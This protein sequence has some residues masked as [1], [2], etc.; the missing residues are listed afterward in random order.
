M[1]HINNIAALATSTTWN[2]IF[3]CWRMASLWS[4]HHQ[5]SRNKHILDHIG[6]LGHQRADDGAKPTVECHFVLLDKF[7]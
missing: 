4:V 1:A 2:T 6:V 7:S 5:S 3:N